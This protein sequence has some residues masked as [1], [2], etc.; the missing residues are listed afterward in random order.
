MARAGPWPRGWSLTARRCWTSRPSWPPGSGSTRGHGRKTDKDDAISIGLAALDGADV[1]PVTGDGAL[2]SLRL[3]CDRREEL[4]AQRTQAVCRLHRLLAE[5]TPGGM[6]REL[7]ANKA[8]AL[9][10]RIRAADEVGRVRMHTA[11]DHLADIRALDARLKYITGQIAAL[12]AES[13]TTL[14][15]LYGIGPVPAPAVPGREPAGQPRP[16]YDGRHPDPQPRNPGQAVLRAQA[17]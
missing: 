16:A 11:R 13:G 4:A 6:R 15:T 17:R 7:S 8:Q 9:L 14:T 2:V 3:L 12:V 1:L 5:L 10:A